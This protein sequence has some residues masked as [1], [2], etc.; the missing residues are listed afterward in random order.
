MRSLHILLYGDIDLNFMD[1]SAVWLISMAQ[2]LSLNP[3]IKIDLLL[4]A[5]E[6]NNHLSQS[7][8]NISNITCIPASEGMDTN[9]G[10]RLTVIEAASL[11][12]K[13]QR[14]NKYDLV[15]IRGFDLVR[16]I[17][18][19]NEF[20]N[21]TVPYLTDFKHDERSTKKERED[22]KKVYE[23][24]N[25]MFLQTEETKLAFQ[26]L[27]GVTGEKIRILTPMVPLPEKQPEFRNKHYR[28]IYSGKFHEDWYTEEII[29]VT[30]KLALLDSRIQTKIVGDKFQDVLRENKN[31]L[32]IKKEFKEAA[33][34][35]WIGS[36]SREKCQEMIEEADIGISWRS[37]FLDNDDSVELSSKLLEYGRL[38][39]PALVRRTKMHEKLLGKDYALFVDTEEDVIAKVTR[40]FQD[41]DLYFETAKKI[42]D[43]SLQYTFQAAHNRLSDFIWSFK[44]EPI[45]IVFAGHD[46]KF[47]QMIIEYFQSHEQFDVKI[48]KFSSHEKHDIKHSKACVEWADV[49]F[50]EWGLGNLVWYSK[51]KKENQ[52]L[53]ARL[54]FQEKDLKFLRMI[55]FENVNKFIAI[56][57]YMLEE[58]HRIFNIPKYKLN[59]LDNLIDANQLDMPKL[60]S[61]SFNL[62]IC[63]ILPSRKRLDIAIDLFETLWLKDNRYHLYIKGKKPEEVPW[64]MA[65]KKE[66][67][68]Y[69]VLMNRIEKAPWKEN[70]QF[71][72]YGN[73]ISEWLQKIGYVLSPSD[74][75]G[76]HVAVSEAIASGAIPV[77]RNW[78]GA[79]TVYPKEYIVDSLDLA[80]KKIE[81]G[82]WTEYVVKSRKKDAK[83]KFDCKK[84]VKQIE[85]I[86]KSSIT[87]RNDFYFKKKEV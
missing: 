77:I 52:I 66:R 63:G 57:P 46:F 82:D 30:K 64:L 37:A 60:N 49:I 84:I 40:I 47:A 54:H 26:R 85:Y 73:D 2:M 5:K 86:I 17:M 83:D 9:S 59:Y 38:G 11:M 1:G 34:I 41:E 65:R 61:A 53:I 87:K 27:V 23:H 15:I 45:K 55:D 58:F 32:R 33:S 31:Q 39:K 62:G 25:F 69:D 70:V 79:D 13:L 18:K 8:E 35:D 10:E 19:Y 48:D 51:H 36:V 67:D 6:K 44:K 7:I 29:K 76:S 56:T 74:Y 12:Q 68:Y 71:D 50:C 24:F 81:N 20:K 78:K 22:L 14:Q 80:M 3:N 28:L 21:I 42:Y 72:G 4:K 75:E 16:E 43:A